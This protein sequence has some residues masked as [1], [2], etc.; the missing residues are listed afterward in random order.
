[1]L[2]DIDSESIADLK[3]TCELRFKLLKDEIAA[4]GNTFDQIDTKTGVALGFTFVVVG[5]VLASVF[6]VAT[7]Q[8]HYAISHAVVANYLFAFANGFAFL[9]T[10]CGIGARW[11]RNFQHSVAFDTNSPWC[12]S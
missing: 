3:L 11:P 6:R 9:G 7:D 2:S 8:S 4:Q 1:M 5:Q 12:K 10:L